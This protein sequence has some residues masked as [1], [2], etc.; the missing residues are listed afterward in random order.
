MH[1]VKLLC[2]FKSA[3]IC[4]CYCI[5]YVSRATNKSQRGGI[6]VRK[7]AYANTIII[8]RY[9]QLSLWLCSVFVWFAQWEKKKIVL[10]L[11]FKGVQGWRP[12]WDRKYGQAP[13]AFCWNTGAYHTPAHTHAHTHSCSSLLSG[14]RENTLDNQRVFPLAKE[15]RTDHASPAPRPSSASP[16][17]NEKAKASLST[18]YNQ[19]IIT[20]FWQVHTQRKGFDCF[21]CF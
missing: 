1:L 21:F 5:F 20:A 14:A 12:E 4:C 18:T 3:Q 16:G 7:D 10:I 15:A 2:K 8:N 11:S 13:G 9:V 17:E 19:Q 6:T